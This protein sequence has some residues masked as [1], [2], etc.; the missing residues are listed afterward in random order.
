MPNDVGGSGSYTHWNT[1]LGS[2]SAYVERFRGNDDLL[3]DM[4][5]RQAAADRTVDLLTG[6]LASELEGEPGF[7]ELREFLENHFRRDLK[8]LS[9]YGWA[10][11]VVADDQATA[12]PECLIRIGQYLVERSYFSPDELPALTRA[13]QEIEYEGPAR[14]LTVV[15]RFASSKMGI[16]DDQPIPAGLQ[17]LG[18]Y[19]ALKASLDEYLRQTDEF[20]QSLAAWNRDRTTN[21]EAEQPEPGAMFGELIAGAFIPAF[22]LGRSDQLKVKFAAASEPF[23]TNGQ[24]NP[25]DKHVHW[26][27]E[28]LAAD[29]DPSESPTILYAL[30]GQPD[31]QAQRAHFG[32]VVLEGNALGRYCLW[33]RGL[34]QQEAKEWDEFVAS[35]RPSSDL[36]GRLNSF[37]FSHGPPLREGDEEGSH[38]AATPREL[39][40][41]GLN[42]DAAAK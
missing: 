16:A 13:A 21:P 9:L 38:L 14:M 18:D 29:A 3:A 39:I 8:N 41:A 24:W 36:A 5:R 31:E 37:R 25:Q 26:S 4:E 34:S 22:D 11:G 23:L 6:W 12:L 20:Q 17:F 15:Q 7:A 40:L 2:A 10:Y 30:M 27:H 32:R 19:A 33:Y 28:M 1:S 35:L 42:G